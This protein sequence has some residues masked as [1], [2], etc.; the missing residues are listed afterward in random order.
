MVSID[1]RLQHY[2]S[3]FRLDGRTAVVLG[4]AS[5]IGKASA[6]A[7]AALGARLI[8]TAGRQPARKLVGPRKHTRVGARDLWGDD[9][10]HD[11]IGA[12]TCL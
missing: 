9:G 3:P 11:P 5:G 8:T 2:R 4:T 7:L 6:E 12:G 10:R 1:D